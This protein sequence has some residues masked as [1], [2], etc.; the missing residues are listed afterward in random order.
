MATSQPYPFGMI[1]P[2]PIVKASI[3]VY[4]ELV[5][6][7][8][9][10]YFITMQNTLGLRSEKQYLIC[11]QIKSTL[12]NTIPYVHFTTTW[13]RLTDCVGPTVKWDIFTGT[14]LGDNSFLP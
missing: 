3:P 6:T 5:K 1:V 13:C 12:Y 2:K 8:F 9:S 11:D 4:E 10:S 14:I 7:V